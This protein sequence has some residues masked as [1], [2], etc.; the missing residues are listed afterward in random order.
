MSKKSTPAA[1][2]VVKTE[3]KAP[4]QETAPA[5]ESPKPSRKKSDTKPVEVKAKKVESTTLADLCKEHG[6]QGRVARRALRAAT[7]AGKLQ[8]NHGHAWTFADQK[9]LTAVIEVLTAL[10]NGTGT[11]R[12]G[13]KSEKAATEAAPPANPIRRKKIEAAPAPVVQELAKLSKVE[14]SRVGKAILE[15][16][17]SYGEKN[18]IVDTA[19]GDW[20]AEQQDDCI[21]SIIAT[22]GLESMSVAAKDEVAKFRTWTVADQSKLV[23]ELVAA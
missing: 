14:K 15:A 4:K 9:L 10:K 1:K 7:K 18:G 11:K 8:H 3:A 17:A 20:T 23:S 12:A 6:V 22:D 19:S 13:R 2:K 21:G 16:I 5:V